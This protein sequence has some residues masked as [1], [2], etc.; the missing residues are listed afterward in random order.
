M[1][2][3]STHPSRKQDD[4]EATSFL[5]DAVMEPMLSMR[6][7]AVL[8][9]L[10]ALGGLV[11]AGIRFAGKPHPPT[12]L[13]MA[14]GFIAGAA[15]TLL[16][17]DYFTIGLPG[18]A[19]VGLLLFLLAAAGGIVLNLGYHWKRLALPIWLVV[20]HALVAV[21]GFVLLLIAVWR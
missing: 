13:A 8:L 15:V 2:L 12:W 21:V 19:Q 10:A 11:M 3:R 5:E 7:A 6:T 16:V 4:D 20:V 18:L 1:H 17:Y 9:A 14:H